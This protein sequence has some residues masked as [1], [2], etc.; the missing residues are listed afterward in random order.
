M[1]SND[2]VAS[3]DIIASDII[4]DDWATGMATGNFDTNKKP[5][6]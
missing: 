2:I 6:F 4:A 5:P 1:I 3:K